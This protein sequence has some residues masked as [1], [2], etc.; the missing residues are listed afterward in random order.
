MNDTAT[1]VFLL[2][3]NLD[4]KHRGQF[5]LS[6]FGGLCYNCFFFFGS[7]VEFKEVIVSAGDKFEHRVTV[8]SK[9]ANFGW[10]FKIEN[11]D[12]GFTVFHHPEGEEDKKKCV[13]E[14][15]RHAVDKMPIVV[16]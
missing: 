12:I 11:Y 10:E 16:K 5:I 15:S 9:K 4:P 6:C 8:K 3:E 14:H 7:G 1:H 13:I 2:E